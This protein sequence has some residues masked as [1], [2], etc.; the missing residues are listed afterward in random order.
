MVY[1]SINKR[2]LMLDSISFASHNRD[3]Y[4]EFITKYTF[5]AK[6]KFF[7]SKD[8]L[9]KV[10]KKGGDDAPYSV[11]INGGAVYQQKIVSEE[12]FEREYAAMKRFTL[13]KKTGLRPNQVRVVRLT[14]DSE[15]D[16]QLQVNQLHYIQA[17]HK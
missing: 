7:N 17:M 16:E 13:R 15:T 6:Y 5:D 3:V 11:V 8:Y 1:V 9:A 14:G 4:K 2:N 12:V 10:M